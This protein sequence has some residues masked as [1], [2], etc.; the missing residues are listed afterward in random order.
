[1]CDT[2]HT[3]T[4]GTSG[5]CGSVEHQHGS[6]RCQGAWMLHARTHGCMKVDDG[7]TGQMSG[8]GGHV[9]QVTNVGEGVLG[10]GDT[11]E[12]VSTDVSSARC[13]SHQSGLS[14][15]LGSCM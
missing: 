8:H 11:W 10:H 3:E 2:S 12:R 1:M 14:D 15:L 13:N 9:E 5:R 6:S 7:C 4:G